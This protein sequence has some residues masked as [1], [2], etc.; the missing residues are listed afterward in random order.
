MGTIT[1]GGLATGLDT[2]TIITELMKLERKPVERLKSDKEFYN[3]QLSAFQTLDGKMESLLGAVQALDTSNEIRSNTA[4]PATEDYFT[5]SAASS[6]VTG[7]YQVE[8][9]QLAKVQKNVTTDGFASK[10]DANFGTGTIT[11]T[12]GATPTDINYDTDSLEDIK[13]AINNAG[14]DVTASIINDG[15]TDGNRIVLTGS[16]AATTF[17][18][19]VSETVAGSYSLANA[20]TKTQD[21]QLAQIAIDSDTT[22]GDSTNDLLV[23]SSTNTITDAIPGVTLSLTKVNTA[24]ENTTVTVA[25]D[26]SAMTT[27]INSFVSAYNGILSFISDQS[28]ADW[29]NAAEMR[30]VKSKIQSLL[31][32]NVGTSGSLNYLSEIGLSTDTKTGLI[33][34]NSS[35][36]NDAVSDHLDDVVKLF[37][38]ETGVTG[39]MDLYEDYLDDVTNS[40]D[41]IYASRQTSTSSILKT[42]DSQIDRLEDRLEQKEKNLRAQFDSLEQLA[43]LMNSQAN[44]LSQQLG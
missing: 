38:G 13:T 34:L 28:D 6:A 39:V 25:T 18:A 8:V 27:K 30:N 9:Q 40:V 24:G 20:F 2:D 7:T 10:T 14:I 42:L 22:D 16:D 26:T 5:A 23:T 37:A 36:F 44:Y 1:F 17:T 4:T 43:S 32:T 19:T 29:G 12:I 33:S 11:I 31:T 3:S 15:S 21:A 41:G 35:T